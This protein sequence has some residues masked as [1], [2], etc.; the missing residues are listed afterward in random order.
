[1]RLALAEGK[2][3]LLEPR[4]WE[5][6]LRQVDETVARDVAA[7]FTTLIGFCVAHNKICGGSNGDS[8][9]A[10]FD[11]TRTCEEPTQSL[12]KFQIK[13]P[14]IGSGSAAVVPLA[15]DLQSPWMILVM[16]DG[17][18]KYARW[19]KIK[20]AAKTLRGTEL[21][22]AIKQSAQLRRSGKLQDDFTLVVLQSEGN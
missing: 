17:V 16:S 2:C 6:I 8:A 3:R 1:M 7:G 18:W 4:I 22:S 5:T 15:A 12:T 19:D 20:E 11:E 14:P 13:N 10:I 9:L 21:I